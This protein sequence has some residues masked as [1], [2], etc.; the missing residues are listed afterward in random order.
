RA[1]LRAIFRSTGP[2]PFCTDIPSSGT[3]RSFR[4]AAADHDAPIS[5]IGMEAWYIHVLNLCSG[6]MEAARLDGTHHIGQLERLALVQR[7]GS[8]K[9]LTAEFCIGWI[10]PAGE[11]LQRSGIPRCQDT[12][13]IN[14]EARR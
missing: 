12:G 7:H 9:A 14:L 1:I 2:F 11:P 10:H 6:M 13:I 3:L 5:G 8:K 4:V